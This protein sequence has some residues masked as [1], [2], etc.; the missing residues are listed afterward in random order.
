MIR[1]L[2]A[3]ILLSAST[4]SA[5]P[6]MRVLEVKD[7]RTLL[8]DR[9]GITSTITLAGIVLPPTDEDAARDFLRS[10]L[11]ASWVLVESD[12]RGDAFV[13]RSPDGLYINGELAR[14][15]FAARSVHMTYL[16]Q[17][18]PRPDSGSGT[19]SKPAKTTIT[20]PAPPHPHPARHH[21]RGTHRIPRFR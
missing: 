5:A 17:L 20:V 8:V 9:D 19:T 18:M 7:S 13:Y 21:P 1:I 10:R 16:G 6:M 11:V 4:L 12:A 2:T 3:A 15:A 14:R